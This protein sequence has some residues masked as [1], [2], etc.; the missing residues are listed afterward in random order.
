MPF[1]DAREVA[2]T[3][4]K[5]SSQRVMKSPWGFKKYGETGLEVSDLF[6]ETGRH[7]DRCACCGGCIRRGW[8]W[9][10]TL[11]LH[12]GSTSFVRPSMGSWVVYGLGSE[13]DNLP[14]FVSISPRPGTVERATSARVSFASRYQGTALGKAGTPAS[15]RGSRTVGVGADSG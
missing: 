10:A 5:G 15:R 2:N 9:T 7:A 6:P 1:D 3:G 4:N 11:F 14:G 13:N 12:C 8:L